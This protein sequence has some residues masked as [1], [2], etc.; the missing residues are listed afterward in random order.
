MLKTVLVIDDSKFI[1]NE[2]ESIVTKQ[3]YEVVGHAK[4]GEEGITMYEK[5]KPDIVTL[6]IIMP[7]IDGI[8][9]AGEILKF[10]PK[11]RIVI[12]SSLYDHDSIEEINEVGL[13][14][15][16]AK[17][18]EADQMCEVLKQIEEAE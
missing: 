2:I 14:Y 10:D 6:D 11:A 12:L 4:S 16:I 13:K 9:T 15:I 3:G 17:P 18:I 5:L 1:V 8:E 7:G